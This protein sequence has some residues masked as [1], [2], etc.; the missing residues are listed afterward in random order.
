[1]KANTVPSLWYFS[2]TCVFRLSPL[3]SLSL[4]EIPYVKAYN[5]LI[6]TRCVEAI[7]FTLYLI[8]WPVRY[9]RYARSLKRI[10]KDWGKKV[11][12]QHFINMYV[13]TDIAKYKYLHMLRST[14]A[15]G[16]VCCFFPHLLL[17]NLSLSA[18]LN[19]PLAPPAAESPSRLTCYGY[20]SA[21]FTHNLPLL[22]KRLRPLF[23]YRPWSPGSGLFFILEWVLILVTTL[24]IKEQTALWFLSHVATPNP[25]PAEFVTA[26]NNTCETHWVEE[27]TQ[28]LKRVETASMKCCVVQT[29]VIDIKYLNIVYFY[30]DD[31]DFWQ[32]TITVLTNSGRKICSSPWISVH[33]PFAAEHIFRKCFISVAHHAK[34]CMLHPAQC[35]RQADELLNADKWLQLQ[36]RWWEDIH[37]C[38]SPAECYMCQNNNKNFM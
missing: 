17:S 34:R 10:K 33:R 4:F 16:L 9:Y 28:M 36:M 31:D 8:K 12:L 3:W 6:Y 25:R 21:L 29:V 37:V 5:C 23:W 32:L 1:M 11:A 20:G 14:C 27:G 26:Y 7:W 18:G 30:I 38:H 13:F 24:Y 19:W 2:S 35:Q 22:Y 15:V